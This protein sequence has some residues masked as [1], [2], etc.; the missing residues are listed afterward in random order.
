MIYSTS[1]ALI[2]DATF[3]MSFYLVIFL[4]IPTLV[5]K[6]VINRIGSL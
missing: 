4:I 6:F 2:V 5:F 1:T 3:N